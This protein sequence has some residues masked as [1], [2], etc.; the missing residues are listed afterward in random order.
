LLA[1]LLFQYLEQCQFYILLHG[2]Q[3]KV[4]QYDQALALQVVQ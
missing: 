1:Y 3:A 2:L 4:I